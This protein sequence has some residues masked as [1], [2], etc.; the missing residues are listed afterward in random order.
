VNIFAYEIEDQIV[1]VSSGTGIPQAQNSGRQEGKGFELEMHWSVTDSMDISANYAY[2]KPE[3][4]TNSSDAP[5][6]PQQQ[7][8]FESNW[9]FKTGWNLNVSANRVMKRARSYNDAREDIDDYTMVNLALRR[10]GIVDHWDV[11]LKVANIFDVEAYEP[12]LSEVSM[13]V[14]NDYPLSGRAYY[15]TANYR[16]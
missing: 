1:F 12:S 6:S 16:F 8:Y 3:D 15:A 10:A 11:A 2:Q 4:K 5:D 7:L 13:F 14:P 9:R